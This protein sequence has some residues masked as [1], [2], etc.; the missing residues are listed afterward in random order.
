MNSIAACS[1]D[2]MFLQ[3]QNRYHS[4]FLFVLVLVLMWLFYLFLILSETT[5]FYTL[6][7]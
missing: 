4:Y 2:E 5:K 1:G 3:N 7:F 6:E